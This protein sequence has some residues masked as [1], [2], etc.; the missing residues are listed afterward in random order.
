MRKAIAFFFLL[1]QEGPVVILTVGLLNFYMH[2][3]L[4]SWWILPWLWQ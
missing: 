2:T 1:R 3:A 4:L